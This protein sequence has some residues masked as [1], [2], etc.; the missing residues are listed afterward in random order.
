MPIRTYKSVLEN[1]GDESEY[2]IEDRQFFSQ[3][4]TLKV[5]GYIIKEE[6]F[7]VE[8]NPMVSIICFEGDD[9]KRKKPT[10]ELSEY[11]TY[12]TE[13]KY[14]NKQI[15]IDIDFSYCYPH[16]GKTK[17]TIDEDFTLTKI[18]FIEPNN[19]VEDTIKLFVNDELLSNNLLKDAYE[20]YK[21][22]NGIPEDTNNINTITYNT[23]P[24]QKNKIYKYILYN[25][26]YYTWHEIRFI[27]GDEITIQTER[28]KRNENNGGLRL[29]GYNKFIAY[30]V[31]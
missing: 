16:K 4:V 12:L 22:Y 27:D 29:K 31:E 15:D 3:N 13:D 23:L 8:E 5:R 28:Q 17:F 10:I 9:A 6:D 7:R 11:N 20:G 21:P 24:T 30:P 26:I 14:Y 18:E 25:N 1:I 2:N 19:V